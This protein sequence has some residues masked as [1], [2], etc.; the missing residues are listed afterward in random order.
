MKR[1]Q[2]LPTIVLH[3][4]ANQENNDNIASVD[5][6]LAI[7]NEINTKLIHFLLSV[8][9]LTLIALMFC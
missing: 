4:N 8:V 3:H 6:A 7:L 1:S 2:S 9:L 5:L